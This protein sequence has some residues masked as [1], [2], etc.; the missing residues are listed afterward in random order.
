MNKNPTWRFDAVSCAGFLRVSVRLR[1]GS[2]N[3]P[4]TW[5]ADRRLEPIHFTH[6]S[7]RSRGGTPLLSRALEAYRVPSLGLQASSLGAGFR[8][9]V[10]AVAQCSSRFSVQSEAESLSTLHQSPPLGLAGQW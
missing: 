4:E 2:G 1:S 3:R 6:P 8:A 10:G 9:T 5:G 7:G